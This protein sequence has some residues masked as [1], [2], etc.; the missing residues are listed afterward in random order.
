MQPLLVRSEKLS[1]IAAIVMFVVRI[2]EVSLFFLLSNQ[3][4]RLSYFVRAKLMDR[5]VCG[6]GMV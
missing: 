1:W 5:R 3:D 6:M 2:I 4:K